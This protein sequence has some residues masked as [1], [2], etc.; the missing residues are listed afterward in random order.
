MRKISL[1]QIVVF[2]VL[3]ATII[4]LGLGGTWLL[5]GQLELG[6]FRGIALVLSAGILCF[7]FAL[8]VYRLFLW[9]FPL[10]A[11]DIK[12][13]SKKE[14][15]YHVYLLFFLLVFYPVMRSGFTPLPVMRLIYLMLGAKLGD[16]TY[17]S[18][19]IL[20]PLFVEVGNNT[21]IGQYALIV[22]HALENE[23]LGHYKV[24]I[25]NNVTIGAHA[26]VMANVTIE[27]N[28]LV[29]TGAIVTKGT[30]ISAGEV[31]AG[32]PAKCIKKSQIEGA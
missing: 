29:A 20:D 3:F 4:S 13:D 22:P 17:S 8:I 30:Y 27:D 2:I 28:A 26:V 1:S 25:G 21:L 31:W 18:G 23:R 5:F 9:K 32:V 19:I 16:N 12:K 14:F 11:G 7:I 6:D 15:I 10:E 24:T